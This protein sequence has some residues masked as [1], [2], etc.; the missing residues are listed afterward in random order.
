VYR[1]RGSAPVSFPEL[2]AAWLQ[3]A[4]HLLADQRYAHTELG[5]ISHGSAARLHQLGDLLGDQYEFTTAAR[6]RSRRADVRI[7]RAT[8]PNTDLTIVDG[9]PATTPSRTI[10][11]LLSIGE[12]GGHVATVLSDAQRSQRLDLAALASRAGAYAGSYG[13]TT[14]RELLDLLLAHNGPHT[15]TGEK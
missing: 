6:R 3:L 2:R 1:V 8:V 11:D 9:L 5:V 15:T 4:P 10:L 14:G 12:D 13:A 7:W